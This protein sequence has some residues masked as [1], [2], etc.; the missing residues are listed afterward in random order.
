MKPEKGLMRYLSL[1]GGSKSDPLMSTVDYIES[2]WKDLENPS[3]AEQNFYKLW[4]TFG[5]DLSHLS[6]QFFYPEDDYSK[7]MTEKNIFG[8]CHTIGHDRLGWGDQL[9]VNSYL[10]LGYVDVY[11]GGLYKYTLKHTFLTWNFGEPFCI[12][13]PVLYKVLLENPGTT[14]KNHFGFC[15]PDSFILYTEHALELAG[16]GSR[17]MNYS[18]FMDKVGLHCESVVSGLFQEIK[19]LRSIS[20]PSPL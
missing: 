7:D 1:D 20:H 19:E 18:Y 12:F 15:V 9:K 8:K 5:E 17:S 11:E 4:S 3:F 14:F 6:V 16:R 13:D 2:W 10:W